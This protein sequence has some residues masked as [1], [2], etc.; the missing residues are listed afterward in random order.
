MLTSYVLI[1]YIQYYFDTVSEQYNRQAC[2]AQ[3]TVCIS[4]CLWTT[5]TML[6]GIGKTFFAGRFAPSVILAQR[7]AAYVLT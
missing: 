7:I 2:L 1:H 3:Q 4:R 6:L 5:N